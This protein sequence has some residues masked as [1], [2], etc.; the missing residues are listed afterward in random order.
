MKKQIKRIISVM[1]VMTMVITLIPAM[2]L[3][4]NADDNPYNLSDGR[5]VYA[6]S[7]N[8]GDTEDR[9][10]DGLENTRWQASQ[11]DTNEWLYVDLGKEANLDHIYMHWEA[12]YA[13]YYKIETSNDEINWTTAYEKK[14]GGSGQQVE[15]AIS[16]RQTGIRAD[17]DLRFSVNWTK[18]EDAHYKVYID[19]EDNDHIAYAGGDNYRFNNH[20]GTQGDVRMSVG[21]HTMTIVAFNPDNNQELG[22]GV[23]NLDAQEGAQG[24]NGV[25][26][27]P[28]DALKQTITKDELSVTKARFVKITCTQRATG[29]GCS[30]FEFQVWGTG[31]SNKPPVDYGDNLALNKTVKCSGT[32]DEWWMYNADGTINPDAYK[33]VKPENAVDGDKNTSFTSYQGEA[34]QWIYVDLGDE[35]NVGRVITRFNEDAGKI[36][37][38]QVSKDAKHWT[39]IHRELRGFMNK[40]DNTTCYQ[41]EVRF[42]RVLG[43]SKVESGSGMG[44]RELEVYE[45]REGDSK[46]NE[47]IPDLPIS[48]IVAN[49]NGK[50]SYV[51]GEVKKRIKQTSNFC[52]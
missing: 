6:S 12:A 23:L 42:V 38:V 50:G 3:T 19:G 10:V 20:G 47:E 14:K 36:Y 8:G 52:K 45:Y 11:S 1:M 26:V 17:G 22:R 48:Q 16:Y 5:A 39:T 27:D 37:D 40:V 49:E 41:E 46:E 32:R 21:E 43:Y 13:K 15:M 9:A 28:Q 31:G 7:A 24:D 18:V 30:L 29:Y 25:D 44:I 51:I 2:Q 34:D 35:Y 4:A 33:Q